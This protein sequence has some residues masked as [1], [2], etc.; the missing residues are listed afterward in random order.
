MRSR[1]RDVTDN[2]I[3]KTN[4]IGGLRSRDQI[5]RGCHDNGL[6]SILR[7]MVA[8]EIYEY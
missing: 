4:E 1:Y 3:R 5:E 2:D 8:R 6:I 7:K